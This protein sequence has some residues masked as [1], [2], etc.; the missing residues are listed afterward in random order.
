[1]TSDL[2]KRREEALYNFISVIGIPVTTNECIAYLSQSEEIAYTSANRGSVLSS[3]FAI[4][5]A[6]ET[7][8]KLK[9]Y[10][11]EG[12]RDTLWYN[13][14]RIDIV[15]STIATPMRKYICENFAAVEHMPSNSL[16]KLIKKSSDEAAAFIDIIGDRKEA[17]AMARADVSRVALIRSMQ[18]TSNPC[19]TIDIPEGL[20]RTVTTQ[21]L[22]ITP[23][24][25]EHIEMHID[26]AEETP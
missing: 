7:N 9:R 14:E 1:M 4:L 20:D 23:I 16:L 24:A 2:L 5:G 10:K 13:E 18:E 8:S 22:T 6:L 19:M 21:P 11:R 3:V 12:T 17:L 26:M 15:N 25:E